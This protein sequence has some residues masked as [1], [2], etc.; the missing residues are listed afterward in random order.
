MNKPY[1]TPLPRLLARAIQEALNQALRWDNN[2]AALTPRLTGRVLAIALEGIGIHLFFTVHDDRFKVTVNNHDEPATW[3]RGTPPALAGMSAT[4]SARTGA[5]QI[6][7]DAELAQAY[8]DLFKRLNPDWE[9]PIARLFGDVAGHRIAQALRQMVGWVNVRG[10]DG[11]EM[12]AEYLREEKRWII[13]PYEMD[14]F[15]IAVDELRDDA[16]RLEARIQ[17][18]MTRP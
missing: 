7:G 18:L 4:N 14:D 8:Q 16:E 15:L 3:I 1:S 17:N 6:Q 9:E 13:S 2:A 5:V 10:R 12:V 11:A